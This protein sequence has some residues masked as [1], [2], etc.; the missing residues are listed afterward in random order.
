LRTARRIAAKGR[1]SSELKKGGKMGKPKV[2]IYVPVDQS[3]ETYKQMEEAGCELQIEKA[4]GN[5]HDRNGEDFIIKPDADSKVMAGVAARRFPIRKEIM[6]SV[7]DLRLI[8]MYTVGYD[9]VDMAAATEK[10]ILV[11]HCPTEANWGGVAEG[12]MA[13]MLALLKRVRE[14][15]RFIKKGGWREEPFMGTYLGRRAD[16][17]EGITIGIIG[18]GR[19]GTR[20]A[21]LLAPWR[22]RIIACDP[23]IGEW[24][25]I[26]HNVEPADL[27][28]LLKTSDV[29]TLHCNLT[30]ETRGI[31]G[32][33]QLA[34][35]KPNAILIN[36]ARG[37][38][39]D[40]DALYDALKEKR[41][42]GA[43]LDVFP[44]EP[45]DPKLSI[46]GLGD[47]VLLSSHTI[48]LNQGGGLIPA[49]PWVKDAVLKALKGD[50][51]NHVRNVDAIPAWK[52]RFGGKSLI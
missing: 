23:Y 42:A 50:V 7:P 43:A 31:I 37:P 18:L 5:I 2:Y 36:A 44:E 1:V 22:V 28:T 21:N 4:G 39:V 26:H 11:T 12:T 17:Y 38:M 32:A 40:V 20:L 30:N 29:V 24:K 49:I 48:T 47:E 19:I 15:D 6:D 8:A 33:E 46:F 9:N 51:P 52:E 27:E 35:M 3:G 45:P 16:G 41:I 13:N 34:M 25:F 14:R 10:G